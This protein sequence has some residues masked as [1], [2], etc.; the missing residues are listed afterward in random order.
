M[1]GANGFYGGTGTELTAS[2]S[3]NCIGRLRITLQ[4]VPEKMIC[5]LLITTELLVDVNSTGGT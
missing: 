2:V 3:V 1:T 4:S 5:P